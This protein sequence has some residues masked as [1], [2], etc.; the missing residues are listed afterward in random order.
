MRAWALPV[1]VVYRQAIGR[2]AYALQRPEEQVNTSYFADKL[3]LSE[4]LGHLLIEVAQPG[5]NPKC[6]P[7]NTCLV[8]GD[9]TTLLVWITTKDCAYLAAPNSA[10]AR[11]KPLVR[12]LLYSI[13]VPSDPLTKELAQLLE[14]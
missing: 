13:L 6:V 8:A 14:R 1:W 5:S 12:A 7:A 11:G 9:C 3:A 4:P 10:L 2:V